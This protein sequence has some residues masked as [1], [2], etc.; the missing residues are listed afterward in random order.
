MTKQQEHTA[1]GRREIPF[2]DD[3]PGYFALWY[4]AGKG[5]S[6]V[7]LAW[8]VF[9]L[10]TPTAGGGCSCGKPA[11]N[12]VGKH[13]RTP[14]GLEDATKDPDAIL[15]WWQRWPDANIGLA[16]GAS[17]LVTLDFDT[18][19]PDFAGQ[20]LLDRLLSEH[21]TTAQRT[22][23]GGYHL[24]YRQPDGEALTN[25]RGS[26]PRGVDVRGHGGYIVL[27][28]GLHYSGNRYTWEPG[29]RPHLA[30]PAPLP[31]FVLD[32]IQRSKTPATVTPARPIPSGGGG[33]DVEAARAWL[34]RL[35]P[36]RCEDYD[37]DGGW[38]GVGMALSQLGPAG[39]GL[40]DEW[41]RRSAKYTPGECERKW[42]TFTPGAGRRLGS[43]KY[44]ADQDDPSG[45]RPAKSKQQGRRPSPGIYTNGDAPGHAHG[46]DGATLPAIKTNNRQLR[47]LADEALS[48][49]VEHN[50]RTPTTPGVYTRG[51]GLA[52]LITGG[53]IQS[54]TKD[55]LTGILARSAQWVTVSETKDGGM[56]TVNV[57]PPPALTSALHAQGIWPGLPEL[58]G[59]LTCPSYVGAGWVDKPGYDA[60]SGLFLLDGTAPG[61]TTPTPRAVAW[62]LGML[63]DELLGD[64][65]FVDQASRAHA[66]ALTLVGFVR[67]AIRGATPMH[68]V[69]APTPGSGKG[70]LVA[71]C[72]IPALGGDIASMAPGRDDEEMRKRLTSHLASGAT[73]VNL[74]N[75]T[76]RLDSP[77][78]AMALTQPVWQD[79]P[80]GLTHMLTLP[81]TTIWSATANNV[82]PSDEIARRCAWI[83]IDPE[84]ERPHERT[85]FR[86]PDL[87]RWARDNRAQL[88]RAAMILIRKWQ[89]AGCPLGK[90]AKGSFEE[91][92]GI[93][94]GIL[95]V[96]G[97]TGFLA[98]D[99]E[100]FDTA[101][102]ELGAWRAFVAA[103][104]DAHGSAPVGVKALFGLASHYD[105]LRPD[106]SGLGL[107]DDILG[108]NNEA[109]RR[110]SLGRNLAQMADRVIGGWKIT[111]GN[112][113]D[114]EQQWR[115]RPAKDGAEA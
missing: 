65:P 47:D 14:N 42:Q 8:H 20:D 6:G 71:A 113:R 82:R 19:K 29:M 58:R 5:K 105:T 96:A 75:L 89:V 86:H 74:D 70:L 45:A 80:L 68:L 97:V 62:A 17:G 60:G 25:R 78:L 10:H 98:N 7:P 110:K 36:W 43:L 69:D 23:S 79:R 37:A 108:G 92:A 22:G 112:L 51:G 59:L 64:F 87:L 66:L 35:A 94:G 30:A 39:L 91:W 31:D 49:L 32:L 54:V 11:C 67:H 38:V 4:A 114:G 106:G 109:G 61:D 1:S 40:W 107:L 56:K 24:L 115:L 102:S 76:G 93:M 41:S 12:S 88:V 81:V 27:A 104:A 48:A 101:V 90:Y 16:C 26:L 52:R 2:A 73:H 44:W 77:V 99:R 46:E 95:D 15:D 9:P 28:P 85:D 3:T 18:A 111:R 57:F 53:G 72:T 34:A 33:D 55:A 103:W 13:P 84:V 63:L 50:A 100:L 83:R 21:P